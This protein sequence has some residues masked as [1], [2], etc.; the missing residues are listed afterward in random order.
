M[1]VKSQDWRGEGEAEPGTTAFFEQQFGPLYS[2]GP[3][4]NLFGS[5]RAAIDAAWNRGHGFEPPTHVPLPTIVPDGTVLHA[6][7][8]SDLCTFSG[9]Y[10]EAK[11]KG[12]ALL[13][14]AKGTFAQVC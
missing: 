10:A 14:M 7:Y 3:L 5:V 1:F 4:D 8:V 2:E 9:R 11:E 12:M 6:D 13:E